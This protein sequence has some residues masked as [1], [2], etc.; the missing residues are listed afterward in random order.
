M[1]TEIEAKYANIDLQ[2]IRAKLKAIGATQI[3]P[4]Q[5]MKRKIFDHP[6]F[7]LNAAHAWV[8]VRDE[9]G[10]IT[11]SY[12]QLSD[13]TLEGT[14]EV[15]V[16][17]NDFDATCDFLFAIGLI[18]KSYQETKREAWKCGDVEITL[19]TWPWIPAFAEIE[20]CNEQ[21]VKKV[22]LELGFDWRKAIFGSVEPIYQMLYD[23]SDDEIDHW[24]S[25]TFTPPPK[26]LLAKK[27]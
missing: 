10:K 8:R 19:D 18:E 5:L 11:L 20:G 25:I 13:R 9:G 26:W 1:Q 12:K 23:F 22:A 16:V 17:V 6:D 7:R 21:S 24:Q 4:E 27:K 14:K 2:A 15:M 3:Y